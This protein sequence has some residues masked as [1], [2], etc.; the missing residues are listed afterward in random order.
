MTTHNKGKPWLMRVLALLIAVL[1]GVMPGTALA[2]MQGIDVSSWQPSN[3][4][5]LVDADLAVVKVTQAT[6]YVNPS[7]HAQAQGAVDTGKALGLYHYAGGYNATAEADW[8]LAQIGDYVGRAVLV[9]DWESNQNAAWGNG[10]WVLQFVQ[11]IHDR[12]RVWPLVYVQASAIRQIPQQVWDTCGLWVAQYASMS[13]TG[14]QSNPWLLGAYGE[15][16]RQYTSTGRLPGYSG[17]LDLNVFRGERWQWT[18]TRRATA[19]ND[20]PPRCRRP[21]L[22]VRRRRR[23]TRAGSASWCSPATA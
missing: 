16:M 15:A 8:F 2:D 6:G 4:T 10:G 7:W 1:F 14:Y 3:I 12:T 17:N 18:R 23:R 5:R 11:R 13:P 21:L 9:L 22:A 19:R 20:R